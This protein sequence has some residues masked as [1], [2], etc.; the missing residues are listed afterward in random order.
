MNT[1]T[2]LEKTTSEPLIVVNQE[3]ITIEESLGAWQGTFESL[4][5]VASVV[6]EVKVPEVN[7]ENTMIKTSP[8][9]SNSTSLLTSLPWNEL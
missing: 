6:E 1:H 9:C 5:P 7:F 3:A 8:T 2:Y 4:Y